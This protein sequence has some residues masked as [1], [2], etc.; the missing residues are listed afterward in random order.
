M[1]CCVLTDPTVVAIQKYPLILVG[2]RRFKVLIAGI[3]RDIDRTRDVLDFKLLLGSYIDE[4][5][6]SGFDQR[7]RLIRLKVRVSGL[8]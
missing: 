2:E 6:F 1:L 8:F 3:V 5:A 7:G 4:D